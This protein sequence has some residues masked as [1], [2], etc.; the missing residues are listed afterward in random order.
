MTRTKKR[1]RAEL[2]REACQEQY[3]DLTQEAVKEEIARLSKINFSLQEDK[4]DTVRSM[5]EVIKDN[6][7]K[8]EYLVEKLDSLR[9]ETAVA[10][11]LEAE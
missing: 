11:R 2:L 6:I 5:N 9:H 4:K 7:D 10:I 8:I 3:E 1:S